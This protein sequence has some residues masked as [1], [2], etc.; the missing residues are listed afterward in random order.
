MRRI[1]QKK[2]YFC[3][4]KIATMLENFTFQDLKNKFNN[5]KNFKM[6]TYL[7][8]SVLV[9]IIGYFGYR[10][11]IWKPAN[12]KS[13]DA[14]WVGLN[15]A[16]QDSTDLAIE[17]LEPVVKKYDGKI[18]GENAQFVLA[19]QYMSKGE[20]KKA[21]TELEGVNVND[22]Y[23]AAMAVGLQGDCHSE[24]KDYAKAGELYLEAASVNENEFTSPLYL[25]KAGLC[26]EKEKD[27]AKAVESYTKIK[28]DFP[29]YATQKAIEKYIARASN[30]IVK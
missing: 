18:G 1:I 5:D 12:E 20:F 19:R 25:F 2:N 29:T 23:L 10:Q 27:F 24:M 4:A 16:A 21:L 17:E 22:T 9:L 11:F 28:D 30:K 13:K 14:Y 7:V 8:G 3:T 6:I 15:Y 26:A